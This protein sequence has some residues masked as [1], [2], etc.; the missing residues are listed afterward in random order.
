M[1]VEICPSGYFKHFIEETNEQICMRCGV[2]CSEC[3][4]S[5]DNCTK[6]IDGYYINALTGLC[7]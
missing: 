4:E 6:C 2:L 1:C 3:T 5:L 7:T